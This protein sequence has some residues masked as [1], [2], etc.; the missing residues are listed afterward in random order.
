MS[1]LETM[2]RGIPNISTDIASIP[3]VIENGKNGFLIQPGD[4]NSLAER[5]ISLLNDP[6]QREEFSKNGF[7]VIQDKFTLQKNIRTLE[8]YY[9]RIWREKVSEARR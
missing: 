8:A 6:L 1:I 3:E 5:M 7:S 9:W 4:K 2:A